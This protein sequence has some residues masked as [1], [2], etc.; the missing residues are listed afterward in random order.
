MSD[1]P[2]RHGVPRTGSRR[3]AGA[4]AGGSRRA[5]RREPIDDDLEPGRFKRF[6]RKAWKPAVVVCGLGLVGMI[7]LFG[8]AYAQTPD[9]SRL[10][11]NASVKAQSTYIYYRDAKKP[12]GRLGETNRQVVKLS[13]VP[14]HVQNAVLAAEQ[15]DFRTEPGIS[16]PGLARVAV[17]ALTGGPIEGASTITQQM[18]RNYYTSVGT[19]RN[20]D[21]KLR[22]IMVAI[23]VDNELSKDKI[24]EQYLNTIYFGRQAYGIQAA[25]MAYFNKPVSRLTPSEGA[26]IAA[27]IQQPGAW[28]RDPSGAQ[29]RWNY[30]IDGM[31]TKGWL[32]GSELQQVKFPTESLQ[33]YRV[34]TTNYR[35]QNGYMLEAVQR[36][37]KQRGYSDDDINRGGLK[38]T[39]TFNPRLMVAAYKAV[40]YTRP[41]GTPNSIQSGLAAVQPGTG[42]VLAFYGGRGYQF[43]QY[44]NAFQA[45]PQAGSAFK[46]YVLAT[47]LSNGVGLRSMVDGRS[48]KTFA[49][50][51]KVSNDG[52]QSYGIINLVTA[53]QKSVNT[54]FVQLG[55]E[56]GL[57]KV[58]QTA[59]SVG[60]A[61]SALEGHR[62]R[63]GLS[64][65][66][67]SVTPVEQAGGFATFASGGNFAQ[68][69]VIKSITNASGEKVED[70][71]PAFGERTRPKR[72]FEKAVVDDVTF[73]L[74]RVVKYGTATKAQL[75]MARPAAGKTGTTDEGRALW[76][77]GYTPQLAA[78]VT[79]FRNDNKPI[80]GI[81]GYSQV[82]GGQIPAATWKAFMDQALKNQ[83]I[84][85]FPP[86]ANVGN[87]KMFATPSPTPT[88]TPAKTPKPHITPGPRPTDNCDPWDPLC[89][90]PGPSGT[91]TDPSKTCDPADLFCRPGGG[92][93]SEEGTQPE[94]QDGT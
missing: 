17:K 44:D 10:E 47:A 25:S 87:R 20:I 4:R 6:I 13:E 31:K 82:Y 23:K 80:T 41:A 63:A 49:G 90:G 1:S 94:E 78:S 54:A 27:L 30:V 45:R 76:F 34:N 68:P 3:T 8:I 5:A 72:V 21:R 91:P 85:A 69:H 40:K 11:A 53:T 43:R 59:E 18:A 9:P 7:A 58:V 36:E 89:E 51:Y 50:G 14:A 28:E 12:L 19:E 15:R 75:N 37:L 26:V 84:K 88:P 42:E 66:I 86:P 62:N 67:A 74:Q 79:M 16:I 32:S 77:V 55:L 56:V 46:P 81:P 92:N 64:L 71:K 39:T 35:N 60:I 38:V 70:P 2:G 52:H 65:G 73:A 57:D 48:P 33:K 61:K 93:G 83:P 24:L 29:D 22:E